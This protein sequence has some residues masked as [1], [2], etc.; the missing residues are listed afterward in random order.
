VLE[1]HLCAAALS[2]GYYAHRRISPGYGRWNVRHQADLLALLA[3]QTLEVRLTGAM[4]MIPRKSVSFVVRFSR[5][6]A[7]L[8]AA[9]RRCAH[10]DREECEYRV[11]D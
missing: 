4:M 5:E 8:S 3:A 7:P 2:D 1:Q 9:R 10:C 11:E 6:P